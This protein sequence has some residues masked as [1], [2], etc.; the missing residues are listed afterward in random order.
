MESVSVDFYKAWKNGDEQ[1]L[2][3]VCRTTIDPQLIK[4]DWTYRFDKKYYKIVDFFMEMETGSARS[5]GKRTPIPIEIEHPF[6]SKTNAR[7]N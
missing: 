5:N 2:V 4:H 6:Q 7:S 3:H 1:K